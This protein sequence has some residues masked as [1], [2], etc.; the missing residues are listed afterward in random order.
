MLY[1][2]NTVVSIDKRYEE[3]NRND[4]KYHRS[5]AVIS[6]DLVDSDGH[7]MG[8][9]TLQNFGQAYGVQVKDS[10]L[11]Q[12]GFGVTFDNEYHE[13][14]GNVTAGLRITRGMPLGEGAG[15]LFGGGI[16]YKTSDAFIVAIEDGIIKEVSIG[17]FGGD[18]ICQMCN[19]SMIRA[20]SSCRHWP[21]EEYEILVDGKKKT[22]TC[23]AEYIGGKLRE[24]SL[25]DKGACP[26][27]E[28]Q[29]RFDDHIAK[30]Y[31]PDSH[32]YAIKSRY[33][34]I[35]NKSFS[36][37]EDF[38]KGRDPAG[39]TA[40]DH[41]EAER[42]K[43]E[44]DKVELQE[45]LDKIKE[46]EADI[47]KLQKESSDK[48]TKIAD[49]EK[50]RTELY[51]ASAELEEKKSSLRSEILALW[52]ENRGLDFTGDEL[53]KY[54]ARIES[55]DFWNLEEEKRQGEATNRALFP[56]KYAKEEGEEGEEGEEEE[57]KLNEAQ[58]Q[59]LK[60][61]GVDPGSQ[62]RG[63]PAGKKGGKGEEEGDHTAPPPP[64]KGSLF[65]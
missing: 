17:G 35:D 34:I 39:K 43:K 2:G 27:A 13:E 64:N 45:A 41:V 33:G 58:V 48:D 7:F 22:V 42:L 46:L 54:E 12:N 51:Q 55:M 4:E 15:G 52:K 1:F 24:V 40:G 18:L 30:G 21:L 38:G 47:T 19:E 9:D 63:D 8:K 29:N 56:E 31:I 57:E 59:L 11:R 5:L 65:Y 53:K 20:D 16:S 32:L 6:N 26:G 28:I 14:A 61:F 25:V 44:K 60:K 3:Q 49:L 37:G 36:F 10:H 62:T 50:K 23:Y